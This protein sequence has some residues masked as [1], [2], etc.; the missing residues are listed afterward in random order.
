MQSINGT[1]GICAIRATRKKDYMKRDQI[2]TQIEAD[3]AHVV[4]NTNNNRVHVVPRS[5]FQDIADGK[6]PITQLDDWEEIVPVIV[7]DW[8]FEL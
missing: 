3:D 5:V 4:I 8:L 7:N 6:I 1:Q 2:E